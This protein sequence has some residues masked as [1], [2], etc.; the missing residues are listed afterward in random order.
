[1][2]DFN[3]DGPWDY[4]WNEKGELAWNEFDWERYLREQDDA[5]RRYVGYYEAFPA[6]RTGSTWWR[7][8]WAGRPPEARSRR[9]P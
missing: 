2:S 1:M 5:M 4:D 7:G 3:A 6:S 8:R 9:R